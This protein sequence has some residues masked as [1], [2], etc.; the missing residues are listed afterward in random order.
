MSYYPLS[1]PQVLH[2]AF[3]RARVPEEPFGELDLVAKRYDELWLSMEQTASSTDLLRL[4]IM[5]KLFE[6]FDTDDDDAAQRMARAYGEVRAETGVLPYPGIER[7]LD[8]LRPRYRLGLLTNGPSDMQW[9]KI[10]TLGLESRFDAIIVAGDVG[11]YKP[12]ARVFELLLDQLDSAAERTLFVGD[13]YAADIAGA[14]RAGLH[15][16]WIVRNS[17]EAEMDISPAFVR[18]DVSELREVLL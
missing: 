4:G 11:I 18:S 2:Q 14:H 6:E 12:D 8:D 3:R 13:S 17:M 5:T 9:D 7:L 16:A 10:R 1:T 15:T